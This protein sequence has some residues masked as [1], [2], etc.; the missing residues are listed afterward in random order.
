MKKRILL[1]AFAM[2][3]LVSNA[4]TE[5]TV[6]MG[7]GYA[8][9]VYFKFASGAS[10]AYAH[11]SWDIAF[12]R[13]A[14]MDM[15]VR[16]NDAKVLQLYEAGTNSAWSTIDVAQ[17]TSWVALYNS[18]AVWKTGAFDEASAQF[19]W[20][21][22]NPVNHH[23][24]GARVFV[25][26][27]AG[28]IYKKIKI[29][30]YF[31]GYTFTYANWDGTAWGEDIVQTIPNGTDNRFFNYF[32]LTTN[33]SVVAEPETTQWDLLFTKYYT[34]YVV[35]GS[36]VKYNVTGVL[37]HPNVEVSQNEEPGGM[38]ENPTVTFAPEI[39][40]IGYDWKTLNSQFGYDVNTNR[41]FYVK[42]AEDVVYRL[43]FNTF[44]SG[45]AGGVITFNYQDVTN[46][47]ATEQFENQVSFG[48]YPNPSSDKRISIV[49]DGANANANN[50]V[51]IYSLTGAKV[52]DRKLENNGF[53]NTD[54]NLS[55]LNSGVY[56]L[57]F[58]SGEYSTTKKIV[59]Q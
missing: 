49:Y 5:G 42:T 41:A 25:L 55:D 15:G 32:N 18:D 27:Y 22:Y 54:L 58:Q 38:P 6:T 43:V 37:H 59:L 9:Q 29:D 44:S 39:N 26:E 35:G 7:T 21:T 11:N 16:V 52:F 36:T 4:Q 50:N 40:I 3:G 34:D 20:G 24:T 56:I 53:T 14:P 13:A 47:L 28:E 31:G 2:F 12:Y 23:V 8:N 30:D 51:S 19:G 17:Q 33:A 48:V 57:K 46:L 10:T 1:A 45:S